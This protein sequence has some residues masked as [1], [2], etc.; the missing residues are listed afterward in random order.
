MVKY[1]IAKEFGITSNENELNDI[2]YS[3]KNKNKNINQNNNKRIYNYN[4]NSSVKKSKE[5]E[6]FCNIF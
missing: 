4:N 5:D 1:N 3:S 6:N 2:I